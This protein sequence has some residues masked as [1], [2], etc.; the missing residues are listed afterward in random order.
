MVNG[1]CL[2]CTSTDCLTCDSTSPTY[3]SLNTT[4]TPDVCVCMTGYFDSNGVCTLC[5]NFIDNCTACIN[6]TYCTLCDTNY[7][8]VNGVCACSAGTYFINNTCVPLMGCLSYNFITSGY[9][10]SQ[11]DTANY[12]YMTANS[13]CLCLANTIYNSSTGMC[14]GNCSDGISL[15]NHCDLGSQN[16][17]NG[18]G[19]SSTC[20]V[21]PGYYC[22]NPSTTRPSICVISTNYSGTF[23]YA[24]RDLSSNTANIYIEIS[25]NDAV[26]SQIDFS[27]YITTSIPTSAISAS[28]NSNTGILAIFATYSESI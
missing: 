26:L 3:R 24:T 4:G 17:V 13:T 9:Y 23:L 21:T 19:C 5:S 22:S 1:Y 8:A 6:S 15:G 20:V 14:E 28:Y 11:C 27:Q 10:C 25:P 2:T 16:G 12:F 18:S 7:T